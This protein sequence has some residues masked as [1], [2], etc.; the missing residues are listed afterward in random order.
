MKTQKM[1][2]GPCRGPPGVGPPHPRWGGH[3]R[4]PWKAMLLRVSLKILL[5]AGLILSSAR[6]LACEC[7]LAK[8]GQE[9]SRG[10]N[11]IFRVSGVHFGLC[12]PYAS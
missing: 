10:A 5:L 4:L 6:S 9:L 7:A 1:V 8:F 2:G 3:H 12:L 11:Q